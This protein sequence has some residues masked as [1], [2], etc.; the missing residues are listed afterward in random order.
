[1]LKKQ[2]ILLVI[3][4]SLFQPFQ[5]HSAQA[6]E[7]CPSFPEADFFKDI[8][9][10]DEKTFRTELGWNE[11]TGVLDTITN[12]DHNDYE[13]WKKDWIAEYPRRAA[14]FNGQV[15]FETLNKINQD[16]NLQRRFAALH[17]LGRPKFNILLHDPNHPERTDVTAL[18]ADPENNDSVVQVASTMYGPVEGRIANPKEYLGKM[19]DC[20]WHGP[21]QGE[22]ASIAAGAATTYRKYFM[23]TEN[24]M[25]SVAG[26]LIPG[27]DGNYYYLLS[28]FGDKAPRSNQKVNVSAVRSSRFSSGDIHNIGI[29][30]HANVDVTV[31]HAAAKHTLEQIPLHQEQKVTQVFNAAHDMEFSFWPFKN[32][33]EIDFAKIMLKGMYE[34][35][36]KKAYLLGKRKVFLTLLGGGVFKNDMKW[37]AEVFE[38]EHLQQFIQDAGLEVN[39]IYRPVN[40]PD[41]LKRLYAVSCRINTPAVDEKICAQET[42]KKAEKLLK[43]NE[44]YATRVKNWTQE[45][46]WSSLAFF[47]TGTIA[48]AVLY[49][50]Y[51]TGSKKP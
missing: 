30:T 47:G 49:L 51:K 36:L 48:S 33:N 27:L 28:A 23:P 12:L 10:V 9:G 46:P 50:R 20:P 7:L 29:F 41:V 39:L 4:F 17:S 38:Q 5:L 25:R 14:I 2:L 40:N 42:M 37:V 16:I 6:V 35:T 3:G 34:G 1:M 8:V 13:Q 43:E 45:K 26:E 24:H 44:S 31:K 11:K 22:R 32:K 19:L 21:A 18:Q 15:S